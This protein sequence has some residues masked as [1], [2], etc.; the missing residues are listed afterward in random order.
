MMFAEQWECRECHWQNGFVRAKCRNCGE[1]RHH[2]EPEIDLEIEREI[3]E[4]KAWDR[5]HGFPPET[6]TDTL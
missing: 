3:Q 1:C 4:A 2:P 5:V 6:R